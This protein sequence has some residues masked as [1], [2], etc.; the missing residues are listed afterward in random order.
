MKKNVVK[1]VILIIAIILVASTYALAA[2]KL[3][4]GTAAACND[5]FVSGVKACQSNATNSLDNDALAACIGHSQ[6]FKT[7]MAGCK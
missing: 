1:K 2:C 3:D 5:Q 4:A 6:N 7:C